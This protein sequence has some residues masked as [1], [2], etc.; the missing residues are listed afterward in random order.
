MS[1]PKRGSW[2][3]DGDALI[4]HLAHLFD[5]G[6]LVG[7]YGRRDQGRVTESVFAVG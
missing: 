6:L 7:G 3:D 1:M 4:D 2:L 5:A